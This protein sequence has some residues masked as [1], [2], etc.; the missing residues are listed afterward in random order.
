LLLRRLVE[1]SDVRAMSDRP[2]LD[3]I[4]TLPLSILTRRLWRFGSGAVAGGVVRL[5]ASF[6][7]QG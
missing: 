6:A 3:Q 1:L 5:A 2:L 4:V 7:V